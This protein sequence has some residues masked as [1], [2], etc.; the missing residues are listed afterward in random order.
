MIKQ[1]KL[2]KRRETAS[3]EKNLSKRYVDIYLWCGTKHVKNKD[4]ERKD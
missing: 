3:K 2:R 4:K 1:I